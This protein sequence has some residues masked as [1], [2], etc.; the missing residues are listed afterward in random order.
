M[1]HHS[2]SQVPC[3]AIISEL[4]E[5][6]L[7]CNPHLT[8]CDRRHGRHFVTTTG[9]QRASLSGG[10]K[11]ATQRY[12]LP[13]PAVAV[14]NLVWRYGCLRTLPV[15]SR[16][17][18][19]SVGAEA[20][21]LLGVRCLLLQRSYSALIPRMLCPGLLQLSAIIPHPFAAA[22]RAHPGAAAIWPQLCERGPR[23]AARVGARSPAVPARADTPC[24]LRR[25]CQ[26]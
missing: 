22:V 15:T 26:S 1:E 14:R 24:H 9:L 23:A 20:Q 2:Q 4:G 6:R 18:T 5:C 19:V 25:S 10:V 17:G 12:A 8:A 16:P 13:P 11:N 21:L 3:P 7:A